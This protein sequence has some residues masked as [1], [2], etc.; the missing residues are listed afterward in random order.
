MADGQT[1]LLSSG[2][3]VPRLVFS[4]SKVSSIVPL[5]ALAKTLQISGPFLSP[6]GLSFSS[7]L[8]SLIVYLGL[9]GRLCNVYCL[10]VVIYHI[11]VVKQ[12]L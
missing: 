2:S 9:L 8:G 1:D 4:L 3:T 5:S 7:S 11:S 10:L 6:T 12:D